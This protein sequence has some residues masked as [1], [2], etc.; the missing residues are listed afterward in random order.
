MLSSAL[1]E[2]FESK[3]SALIVSKV[4]GDSLNSS[5]ICFHFAATLIVD[6]RMSS[7]SFSSVG[8]KNGTGTRH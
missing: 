5:P 2:S 4:P 3:Q 6:D 8:C 1:A 7:K